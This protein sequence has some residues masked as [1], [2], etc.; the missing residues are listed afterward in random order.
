MHSP[1]HLPENNC[2]NSGTISRGKGDAPRLGLQLNS[3]RAFYAAGQ[4]ALQHRRRGA[5][6]AMHQLD[7]PES[8]ELVRISQDFLERRGQRSWDM[9]ALCKANIEAYSNILVSLFTLV[10]CHSSVPFSVC[11]FSTMLPQT[12]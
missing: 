6:L 8:R 12:C 10:I 7:P 2:I 9:L 5:R 3:L 11:P 1:V 4:R